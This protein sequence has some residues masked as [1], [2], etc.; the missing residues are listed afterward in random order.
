MQGIPTITSIIPDVYLQEL[1]DNA[2]RVLP[3]G[4][5]MPVKIGGTSAQILVCIKST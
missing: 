2:K 1:W 5:Q 3:R 4:T